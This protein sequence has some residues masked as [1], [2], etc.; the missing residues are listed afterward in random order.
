MTT[1]E[2]VLENACVIVAMRELLDDPTWGPPEV[3]EM[4]QRHNGFPAELNHLLEIYAPVR[5]CL[6]GTAV[7]CYPLTRIIVAGGHTW[8]AHEKIAVSRQTGNT[9]GHME[10]M[11]VATFF[12]QDIREV[13]AL[14]VR[15]KP[16]PEQ[17]EEGS[18]VES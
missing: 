1:G 14:I 11:T 6:E 18:D 7:D 10:C 16:A 5:V 8:A 13:L 3:V 4:I 12:E 2:I 15:R 9:R 17:A